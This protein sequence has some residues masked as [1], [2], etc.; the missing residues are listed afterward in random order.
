[1]RKIIKIIVGTILNLWQKF[2]ELVDMRKLIGIILLIVV[3]IFVLG[4]T[5]AFIN[6]YNIEAEQLISRQEEVIEMQE[7]EIT[8][9]ANTLFIQIAYTEYL[10]MRLESNGINYDR[11]LYFLEERLFRHDELD[12]DNFL[13][14]NAL[15]LD[16]LLIYA[17]NETRGE[18]IE[19]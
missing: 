18:V 14:E 10:K 17:T 16:L 15:D 4:G 12:D 3:T 9:L 13:Y 2:R 8:F 7:R 6:Y 5:V 1:M 11:Y 19:E